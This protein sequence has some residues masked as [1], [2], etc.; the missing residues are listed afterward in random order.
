MRVR[1]AGR[2][3]GEEVLV[4]HIS[5]ALLAHRAQHAAAV[6]AQSSP[7]LSAGHAQKARALSQ[8]SPDIAAG[9]QVKVGHRCSSA[10]LDL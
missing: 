3:S 6:R 4:R 2:S 1:S 10:G 7:T 8:A 5:V 9:Y